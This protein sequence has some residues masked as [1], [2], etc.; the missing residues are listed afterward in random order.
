MPKLAYNGTT[1]ALHKNEDGLY[2][3]D[4]IKNLDQNIKIFTI[5]VGE[6]SED[7]RIDVNTGTV[8]E[9]QFADFF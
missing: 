5:K 8:V 6:T 1:Y 9:D 4:E 3:S 7:T 2:E